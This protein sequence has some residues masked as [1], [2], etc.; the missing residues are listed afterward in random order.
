VENGVKYLTTDFIIAYPLYFLSDKKILVTDSL[1]P[2]TIWNFLP[3]LRE[4]VE[5]VPKAKK[6]YLFFSDDHK[7]REWHIK[8]TKVVRRRLIR[9]LKQKK[10]RYRIHDL[11]YYTIVI[12]M[13][14]RIWIRK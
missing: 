1:G 6:A 13:D 3:D 5:R 8:A 10:I 7:R 14:S 9:E 2:L 4:A 12:P 11:E